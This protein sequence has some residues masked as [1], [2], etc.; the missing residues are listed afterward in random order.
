MREVSIP[1]RLIQRPKR[2][3]DGLYVQPKEVGPE[4]ELI[5]NHHRDGFSN[6]FN[7]ADPR[8]GRSRTFDPNGRYNCGACNMSEGT[9]CLLLDIPRIDREAGS[10]G[11]WE[12]KCAGDPELD[13]DEKSPEAATYGVAANGKGFGCHR[14]PY[15]SAAYA[16]DSAGRDL[17]CGKGDMRVYGDACCSLNGA[18]LVGETTGIEGEELDHA[19]L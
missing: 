17:Y 4:R 3:R 18:P 1:V 10:C 11:D 12:D 15:A 14:C 9:D 8:T 13:L 19:G 5:E 2:G 7:Y 16:E 6:H